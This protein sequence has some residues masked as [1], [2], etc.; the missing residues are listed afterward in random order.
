MINLMLYGPSGS[1]K[2]TL[3]KLLAMAGH[4]IHVNTGEITR[5]MHSADCHNLP[6]IVQDMVYSMDPAKAHV[7]DHFYVHTYRQL[8]AHCGG[9]LHVIE[10]I[11]GR[12]EPKILDSLKRR[13]WFEQDKFI[14]QWFCQMK[15]EP[16]KVNRLD[17]GYDVSELISH[18]ILP[19]ETLPVL[20]PMDYVNVS[21]T[22]Q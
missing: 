5:L 19:Y 6:K 16:I 22:N 21:N 9:P 1:G 14:R 13:R 11:E 3:A 2:T 12:T 17:F 20:N 4:Y 7:F 8:A 18:G 15:I 10:V